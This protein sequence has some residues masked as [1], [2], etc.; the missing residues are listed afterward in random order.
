MA[1]YNIDSISR[2]VFMYSILWMNPCS[3]HLLGNSAE[4]VHNLKSIKA[5]VANALEEGV[6]AAS[7]MG[8]WDSAQRAL[9]SFPLR[10]G[11][12]VRAK[13]MVFLIEK[14]VLAELEGNLP[15]ANLDAARL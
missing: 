7:M 4:P 10:L 3:R 5:G 6:T 9:S 14:Q 15:V 2:T 11:R 12:Q 8:V 1:R 13:E